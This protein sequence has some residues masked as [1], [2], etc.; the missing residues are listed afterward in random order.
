[1]SFDFHLSQYTC[2]HLQRLDGQKTF[3]YI[4]YFVV[5]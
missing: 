5:Y 1:M 3:I 4:L 2:A